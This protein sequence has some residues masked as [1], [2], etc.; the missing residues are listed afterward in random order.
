MNIF[1]VG[2]QDK[3]PSDAII[4]N[5]TS[6]SNNWSKGLSPFFL[7]PVD[8]YAGLSAKNVENAW[9]FAKVYPEHVDKNGDPNQDYWLWATKGWD[10]SYAHR[11]PMGKGKIPLYSYWDKEKLSYIEARKKIYIPV[12]AQA[13]RKTSTFSS[14]RELLQQEKDVYLQDFDGYNHKKLGM[15]YQDVV[16]C[17]SKKMGHAFVLAMMLESLVDEDG[18][19][20]F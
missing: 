18:A 5:T 12:Y 16:R 8:L 17:E 10:D 3:V 4:V 15:S 9:Q 6:R 20:K 11:Y 13:V 1:V 2:F 19:L 14:L 7:G